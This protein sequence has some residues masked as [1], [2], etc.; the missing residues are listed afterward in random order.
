M[1]EVDIDVGR[2]VTLPGNETA[3]QEIG[4]RRINLGN[5]Q[6]I[7]HRRVGGRAAPLAKNAE[8]SRMRD[9]V[10]HRQKIRLVAQ[11][12]DQS[13]F[14]VD[15]PLHLAGN[16]RRIATV[17]AALRLPTQI[18]RRGLA[19]G[20]DFFGILIAQLVERELAK[21]GDTHRLGQ[22][23]GRIEPGQRLPATQMA[24]AIREQGGAGLLHR[25]IQAQR[26]ERI[27]QWPPF[28][29]MH[30]DIPAGD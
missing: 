5:A 15:L 27:L 4:A 1:L 22:K 9:D 7:A 30:M 19:E 12:A 2:L 14:I 13:Q 23:C 11:F 21:S 3:K 20:D 17:Q 16:A 10:I 8:T 18:A 25:G 28:A 24:L 26:R 29:H 6:G